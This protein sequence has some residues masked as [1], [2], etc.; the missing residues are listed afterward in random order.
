MITRFLIG[1]IIALFIFG[2]SLIVIPGIG[3]LIGVVKSFF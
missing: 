2:L 1:M 3:I